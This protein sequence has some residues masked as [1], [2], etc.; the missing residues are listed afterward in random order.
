MVVHD[1][2]LPYRKA[3]GRDSERPSLLIEQLRYWRAQLD[4]ATV[5]ELPT[6]QSRQPETA[7]TTIAHPVDVPLDVA[8]RMVTLTDRWGVSLLDLV[9]AAFQVILARYT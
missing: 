4:G 1:T 7:S 3:P 9:V 6:D 8:T 2:S 5:P